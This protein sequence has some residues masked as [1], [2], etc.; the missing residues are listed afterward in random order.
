MYRGTGSFLHLECPP[1]PTTQSLNAQLKQSFLH[2]AFVD[3]LPFHISTIF[4]VLKT[5]H[6]LHF[7]LATFYPLFFIFCFLC[8]QA[9]LFTLYFQIP[10]NI[11]AVM[12]LFTWTI[13]YFITFFSPL[14]KVTF[15]SFS[16]KMKNSLKKQCHVYIFL[17]SLHSIQSY[18]SCSINIC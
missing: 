9:Y 2:E 11:P 18:S 6:F 4:L 13:F 7:T 12:S 1:S 14:F 15:G 3:E 17:F 8:S 10:Q 16:D 5:H